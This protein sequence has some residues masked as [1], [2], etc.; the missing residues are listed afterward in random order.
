MSVPRPVGETN[1]E[2]R[3][4]P[5]RPGREP[6]GA[7]CAAHPD[8]PAWA[9]CER[10]GDFM[11]VHCLWL[12]EGRQYCSACLEILR[13]R[14]SLESAQ[15]TFLLL[16]RAALCWAVFSMLWWW[17]PGAAVFP[18]LIAVWLGIRALRRIQR[19]PDLPGRGLAMAA[20]LTGVFSVIVPLAIVFLHP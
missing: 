2:T 5:A 7:P 15:Q 19:K 4:A 8:Q 1:R 14:G 11:C 9:V 10:C 12:V 16:P 20:I 6:A 18:A 13:G 17:L 3:L